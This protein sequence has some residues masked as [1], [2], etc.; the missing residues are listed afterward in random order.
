MNK[1]EKED[2]LILKEGKSKYQL[3]KKIRPGSEIIEIDHKSIPDMMN[4]IGKFL[5]SDED[6]IGFKYFQS[7]QLFEFYRHCN[8]V[9]DKDSIQVKYLNKNSDTNTIY[10]QIGAAP[11]YTITKRLSES[12]KYFQLKEADM[13]NFVT[14]GKYGVFFIWLFRIFPWLFLR[15]IFREVI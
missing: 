5:S 2:I 1:L 8:H 3:R 14:S 10:F 12:E 4:E 11:V 6:G 15:R 7:A 9:F 13:G